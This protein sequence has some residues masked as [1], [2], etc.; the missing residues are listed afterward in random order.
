ME[1]RDKIKA[2]ILNILNSEDPNKFDKLMKLYGENLHV[3][4]TIDGDEYLTKRVL[5]KIDIDL[6][7][8]MDF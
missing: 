3:K 2:L 5:E 8:L 6:D 7:N 1:N 4:I